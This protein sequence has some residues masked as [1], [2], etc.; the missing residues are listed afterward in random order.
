MDLLAAWPTYAHP[1]EMFVFSFAHLLP[2]ELDT[3][4]DDRRREENRITL[5][6]DSGSVRAIGY[7]ALLEIDWKLRRSHNLGIRIH[8]QWC[9]RGI[10]TAVL[11]AVRDWWFAGGMQMLRLDVASSNSRAVTCYEKVGFVRRDE[12]WREDPDL[13][14]ADLSDPKWRFLDGHVR[15]GQHTAESRFLVMELDGG[16]RRRQEAW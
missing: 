15:A 7:V 11:T 3:L 16:I 5:V 4:F 13:A 1:H 9:D 2:H 12:F 6:A 14:E 10:G 8:P